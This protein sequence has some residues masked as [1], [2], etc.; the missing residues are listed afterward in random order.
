MAARTP[1]AVVAC[2]MVGLAGGAGGEGGS[3]GGAGASMR[4]VE[5]A[6][7]AICCTGT[8]SVVAS[9]DGVSVARLWTSAATL[10]TVD[11]ELFSGS[12]SRAV[13]CTE[14]AALSLTTTSSA[15]G[16]RAR[17]ELRSVAIS[18]FTAAGVAPSIGVAT[19]IVEL[20]TPL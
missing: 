2:V 13:S 9:C 17:S 18:A 16:N 7:F 4:S 1:A 19:V 20:M 5:V 14:P 8:P 10:W 11:G 3:G 12:M 6:T 15:A